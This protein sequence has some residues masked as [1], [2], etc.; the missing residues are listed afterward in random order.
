MA[1]FSANF[2]EAMETRAKEWFFRNYMQLP[3]MFPK[4][5]KR[6]RSTTRQE[7]AIRAAGFGTFM[8]K[9]EGTP[10]AFDDPVE[11]SRI[12][13]THTTFALGYR[14]T[15][16]AIEDDQWDILDQMPADLGDAARD[17]QERIAWALLNDAFA[18][19]TF[20]GLDGLALFSTAHTT[21]RAGVGTQ[22][23]SLSPAIELGV[24]GLEAAMTLARNTQSEEGR[25]INVQLRKLLYNPALMHTAFTLLN[26]EYRM[27]SA[28]NDK[29]TV[30]TTRSGISP[31]EDM[32]VPYITS[33]TS[34]SLHTGNSGKEALRWFDRANLFFERGRDALTWDQLHWGGYR[35]HVALRDWR[36]HVGSNFA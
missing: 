35:A 10:V 6:Q 11:G 3:L 28:D 17:H 23:N 25:Q 19:N 1:I 12:R 15:W 18:G 16:E 36:G 4:I 29:S 31:V 14:A 22:S 5:F 7:D 27:G 20:T 33:T 2:P 26:T 24:A 34:W 32:G 30:A 8:D 13:T 21:L 9:A